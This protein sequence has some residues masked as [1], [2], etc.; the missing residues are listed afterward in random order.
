M[1]IQINSMP[2]TPEFWSHLDRLVASSRV[3]IDR[4]RGSH[5]PRYPALV[6]PL[7]YGYLKGISSMDGGGVDVWIGSLAPSTLD[8]VILTVDLF[9]HDAEI[10]LLLGCTES[11]KRVILDFLNDGSMQ[12]MLVRRENY[13]LSFMKGRRS[14]RRFLPRPVP[15]ETLERMLEAATWAPSSHNCQPWRL[16]VLTKPEI[17]AHLADAMGDEL[18]HDLLAD[19]L[20]PEEIEAQAFRSRRRIIEA[21]AAVLLCL[22]STQG[23]QFPDEARQRAEMLMGVQSVAMAG[24]NL[25]LA[26]HA[27]GLGGVWVCAPLFAPQAVRRVLDLPGEWQPQGL[28]LVGYPAQIP[29]PRLRRTVIEITRYY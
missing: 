21:P 15:A 3:V 7:D 24:Q 16:A 17:K 26:A 12:A 19:G 13:D 4:P 8:S 22:D 27:Q 28:V 6:Y 23:D 25:L 5:H 1:E 18:R 20:A 9:K 29:P 10:K 11:E 2:G 14:V